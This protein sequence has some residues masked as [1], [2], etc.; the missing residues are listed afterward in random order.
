MVT[1]G[2]Y[3]HLN[4]SDVSRNANKTDIFLSLSYKLVNQIKTDRYIYRYKQKKY[5]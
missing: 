3:N 2:K 1:Y 4:C 5:I